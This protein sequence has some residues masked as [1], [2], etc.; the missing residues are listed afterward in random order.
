MKVVP[1]EQLREIKSGIKMVTARLHSLLQGKEGAA[2]LQKSEKYD[3]QKNPSLRLLAT[4]AMTPVLTRA[5]RA[6]L[7]LIL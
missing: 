1:G 7:R 5:T 2:G 4:A 6:C 3:A